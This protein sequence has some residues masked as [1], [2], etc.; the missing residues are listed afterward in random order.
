MPS[1]ETP[2]EV[3]DEAPKE[4]EPGA[5]PVAATPMRAPEAVAAV[6]R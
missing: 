2:V 3:P 5:I 4:A 1:I 6:P